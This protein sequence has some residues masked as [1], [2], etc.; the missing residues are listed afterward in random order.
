MLC[1]C[2]AHLIKVQSPSIPSACQRE[3]SEFLRLYLS[4]CSMAPE[5]DAI[6]QYDNSPL[7]KCFINDVYLPYS[8]DIRLTI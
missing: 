2:H 5:Y 6:E 1:P 3:D 7:Y 8:A 4:A